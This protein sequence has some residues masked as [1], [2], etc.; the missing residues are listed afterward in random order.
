[1]KVCVP[2]LLDMALCSLPLLVKQLLSLL[3]PWLATANNQVGAT[4][5]VNQLCSLTCGIV[6]SHDILRDYTLAQIEIQMQLMTQLL[7]PMHLY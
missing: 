5:F 2:L 6:Q 1:M 4:Y 3:L 7:K